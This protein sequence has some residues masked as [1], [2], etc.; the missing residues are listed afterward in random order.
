MID[1]EYILF[2][3]EALSRLD[4]LIRRVSAWHSRKHLFPSSARTPGEVQ[5]VIPALRVR[6]QEFQEYEVILYCVVS[7]KLAF[8]TGDFVSGRKRYFYKKRFNQLSLFL[9]SF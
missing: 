6:R 7:F 1:Q 5:P 9:F 2:N 8:A 4:M 3:R